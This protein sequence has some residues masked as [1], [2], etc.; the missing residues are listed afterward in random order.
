M[1]N[2]LFVSKSGIEGYGVYTKSPIKKGDFVIFY[3]GEIINHKELLR[4]QE[5]YDKIGFNKS[6]VFK[7]DDDIILDAS[8]KNSGNISKFI[9]HSCDPNCESQIVEIERE[10]KIEISAI[11]NIKIGDELTMDY[12]FDIEEGDDKKIPCFCNSKKC[13]KFL[14]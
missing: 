11:K 6:Y 1:E 5:Y 14:N 3:E 12:N 7:I 2:Y 9:N 4:R 10:K 8:K 13:R